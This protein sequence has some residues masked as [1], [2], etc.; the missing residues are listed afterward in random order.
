MIIFGI[1]IAIF[2]WLIGM[3]IVMITFEIEPRDEVGWIAVFL[4]W[5]LLMLIL[6]FETWHTKRHL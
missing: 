1:I 5:P 3:C 4:T 6:L 2:L